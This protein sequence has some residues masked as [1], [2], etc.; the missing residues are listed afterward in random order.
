M[1][2]LVSRV[3]DGCP[4]LQ[5]KEAPALDLLETDLPGK[6]SLRRPSMKLEIEIP[7]IY[8]EILP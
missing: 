8:L 3:W 7:L 2:Q 1:G 6:A 4:T 5:A